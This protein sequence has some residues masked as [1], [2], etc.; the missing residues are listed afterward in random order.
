[1]RPNARSLVLTLLLFHSAN[2]FAD[3]FTYLDENRKTVTLEARL[4]GTGQ[5]FHALER[6]DGQIQIVP[7]GAVINRD[8][9][10]DP[11]PI[12]MSGMKS[13]LAKLF[14][15]EL[16][17]FETRDP[18]LVALVLS[19]PI[20]RANERNAAAITKKGAD[21]MARVDGVFLQ[22]ARKMKLPLRDPRFPLA[23][24]IFESDDDFNKYANEATGGQGLTANLIAG[25]YSGMTNWLTIRLSSCDT[26]EVPLHEAIHLQMYNRVFQRFAPIPKWFDE[27]IAGGF[28]S[29]GG[30]IDVYPEKVNKRYAR[31]YLALNDKGAWETVVAD[32]SAFTADV[33]AGNAYTV[34]WGMHWMLCTRDREKY[35]A[36]VEELSRREPLQLL[37]QQ[38]RIRQVEDAFG[39]TVADLQAGFP[40][41]LEAAIRRGKIDLTPETKVG[42]AK[43][44][45]ALGEASINAVQRADFGG[46]LV[47]DGTLRNISPLRAMTFYVTVETESGIYA[48]WLIHDLRPN[49]QRT[50]DRQV[51][52]KIAP[53]GGGG[54]SSRFRVWIRSVPADSSTAEEWK[55]GKVPGPVFQ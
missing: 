4:I 40:K 8:N 3:R 52:S 42:S 26:F 30:R 2:A 18:F 5:G 20:D 10:G 44:Q 9:T 39:V 19:S 38:E 13:L 1:M 50:L 55:R 35:R 15:E 17:R 27:G 12:D 25:F 49:Q 22:F 46:Q 34:A 36:Y 54:T 31:Q 7:V 28:E 29:D 14:G 6:T 51:A 43:E 23:L 21:F 11:K 53:N 48:D 45:Q 47:V 37:S 33:L 24:V 32:D 41:A 16:V